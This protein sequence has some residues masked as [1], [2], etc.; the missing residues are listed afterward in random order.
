MVPP[1]RPSHCTS[2]VQIQTH[3]IKADG[4]ASRGFHNTW[5]YDV[6]GRPTPLHVA[7]CTDLRNAIRGEWSPLAAR[8]LRL[9]KGRKGVRL[10]WRRS[11]VPFVPK[12]GKG[13]DDPGKQKGSN[14]PC[15]RSHDGRVGTGTNAFYTVVPKN[16]AG[17]WAPGGEEVRRRCNKYDK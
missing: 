4:G 11:S 16:A 15:W 3:C 7:F 2:R 13:D 6:M 8:Q 10:R 5:N 14:F 17:K 9:L 1:W 12:R